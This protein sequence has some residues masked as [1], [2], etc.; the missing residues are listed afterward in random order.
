RCVV[1]RSG[2]R[3][4]SV[5][6]VG[7]RVAQNALWCATLRRHLRIVRRPIVKRVIE[8]GFLGNYSRSCLLRRRIGGGGPAGD[9]TGGEHDH[10]DASSPQHA[11]WWAILTFSLLVLT[12]ALDRL[13]TWALHRPSRAPRGQRC[14]VTLRK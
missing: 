11:S 1:V 2:P 12:R 9:T 3:Q 5:G 4:R 7:Q 13:G 14:Y 10:E 8:G 6:R